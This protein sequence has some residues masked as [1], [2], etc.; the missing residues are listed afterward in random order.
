MIADESMVSLQNIEGQLRASAQR[1]IT[2]LLEQHPEASLSIMRS[3]MT[4]DEN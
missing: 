4:A 3:W 2:D 1:K